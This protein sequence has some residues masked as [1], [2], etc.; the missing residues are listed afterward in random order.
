MHVIIKSIEPYF[1][2]DWGIQVGQKFKVCGDSTYV[3]PN[4][5]KRRGFLIYGRRHRPGKKGKA[6]VMYENQ[7]TI[8]QE[9]KQG[10]K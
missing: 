2:D 1:K 5:V 9:E 7:V 10:V 6:L 3:L 8:C 4:G